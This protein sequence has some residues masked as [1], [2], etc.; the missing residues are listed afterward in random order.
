[1]ARTLLATLDAH[2][3]VSA[4]DRTGRIVYANALFC[5]VS[6]YTA[7]E[8][9]GQN[10][11][12]LK[13]GVHPPEFFRTLWQTI[14]AGQ[15]WQGEI[16]NR[17][18]DGSR[19]WVKAT[20]APMI[21]EDG[22]IAGYVSIRTE[23]TAL[24]QAEAEA[25]R[26]EQKLRT[27]LDCLGEGVYTLDGHGRLTYINAEGARMLGYS[28]EELDGCQLHE[29]IHHHRPDGR[30]LSAAECPIHL[31]MREG[32]IYRSDDEV[33]FRKNGKPLP[34]KV[35]GAPLPGEGGMAGSVAVFSDRS[36]I[37]EAERRLIQAKEAAEEAAR[38]KA[39]FLAVISHEIRTPLNGVIG[40]AELLLD[41]PLSAEQLSQVRTI[42]ESADHLL[43]L[44]GDILDYSKLDAGAIALD[45]APF[46]LRP[47]VD[48]CAEVVAPRLV[49][50]PVTLA[51]WVDAD[52]PEQLLGDA[53][54]LKQILLNLLG[55]AVK[56][57]ERG[58][59]ELAVVLAGDGCG[60]EISVSDTGIG[61]DTRTQAR[62]FTPFTQADAS[63]T[64]RY[65]GTGL[66]LAITK[67]LVEAMG[68]TIHL[69]SQVGLGSSFYV[70]LPLP[71]VQREPPIMPMAGRSVAVIG[72]DAA[73]QGLWQRLLAAW[74]M[75]VISHSRVADVGSL[76][77]QGIDLGILLDD[78]TS[79]MPAQLPAVFAAAGMP[80]CVALPVPDRARREA[81]RGLGVMAVFEPPLTKARVLDLMGVGLAAATAP[82][83][84]QPGSAPAACGAR[85]LLAE[86]NPVNQRVAVAMLQRLG[87]AVNVA[88]DGQEA[89]ALWREGCFDLVLMDCLMPGMD[90]Y[91]ATAE[92]RRLEAHSRQRTPIVA[93]TANA[94]EGDRERCLA[95]GMDDYITKPVTRARLE[96]V[97]ARWLP[98]HALPRKEE[99]MMQCS[100]DWDRAQLMAATGGD[101]A[102][103][104]EILSLFSQSLPELLARIRTSAEAG[105]AAALLAAA[106]ELKG[107]AANVGAL[108]LLQLATAI[109][110][111]AKE[112]EFAM[113]QLAEL[114]AACAEILSRCRL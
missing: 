109:E 63:T 53:T 73:Q 21:G 52:V 83:P 103:A 84:Q 37:V 13:S 54:R 82:W 58:K 45:V 23:I 10:H 65:G 80:F 15:V 57:T 111:A 86:D 81:W 70:R 97:L 77:A 14:A 38:L 95:A 11:R 99:D 27:I 102:L 69:Q 68:G 39:D 90:G 112:G 19:Y 20:I 33:F 75:Q 51:A 7:E 71:A 50:K 88:V 12:L 3:I 42:K 89:V 61:I 48:A 110:A 93:M 17:R 107:A 87:H 108:R 32:R 49:D 28:A 78:P 24:K 9:L 5:A 85:I 8:L 40:M 79:P 106:H 22:E 100:A 64:R 35:T 47:L 96:E 113:S 56:F 43:A 4:T 25:R 30:P 101:E 41:T 104:R 59:V 67:K 60:V 16:C 92:I 62:L 31:A 98:V 72:A 74:R 114:P 2:A 105:D 94:L 91:A 34:V 1:M 26:S 6:G 66:G 36:A 46:A 76:V 55:N 18:K 44:I 29:L